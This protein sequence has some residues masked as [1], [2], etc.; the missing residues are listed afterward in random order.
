MSREI[1]FGYS[2]ER[3]AQ[4]IDL[5]KDSMYRA[6]KNGDIAHVRING[7]I[8]IPHAALVAKFGEPGILDTPDGD[9]PLEA[10]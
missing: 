2:V 1:R 5:G 8:V 6:V 9:T 3:A 10:A 4:L 7:R